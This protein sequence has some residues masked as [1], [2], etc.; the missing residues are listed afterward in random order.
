[1]ATLKEIEEMNKRNRESTK[2]NSIRDSGKYVEIFGQVS[3]ML[4]SCEMYDDFCYILV[5]KDLNLIFE[6]CLSS[7]EVI[8]PVQPEG[9]VWPLAAFMNRWNDDPT[10]KK[11]IFIS[12]KERILEAIRKCGRRALSEF[13]RNKNTFKSQE[14]YDNAVKKLTKD[15]IEK[16]ESRILYI[17]I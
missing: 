12:L 7:Y 9:I 13:E 10:K 16:P 17:S 4:G 1:M 6:P 15:Y 3:Y 2:R 14:F 5:D 8:T 11:E